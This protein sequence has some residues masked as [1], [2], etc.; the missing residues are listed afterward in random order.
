MHGSIA[1]GRSR[2]RG[3]NVDFDRDTPVFMT[4]PQE[5]SLWLNTKIDEYETARMRNHIKYIQLHRDILDDD[6]KEVKPCGCCCTWAGG[7]CAEEGED[8]CRSES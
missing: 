2:N 6:R 7:A 1:M 3:G 8:R 4:A 5:V